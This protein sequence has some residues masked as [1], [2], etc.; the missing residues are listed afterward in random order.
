[1]KIFD[2]RPDSKEYVRQVSSNAG[3]IP[4]NADSQLS[5]QDSQQRVGV[6]KDAMPQDVI[7]RVFNYKLDVIKL[8]GSESDIY[9]DNLKR[10]LIPDIVPD[11]RIIKE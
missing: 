4:D 1:M 7:T 11:I 9:I 3:I 8:L 6:F 2:F 5:T 10:T